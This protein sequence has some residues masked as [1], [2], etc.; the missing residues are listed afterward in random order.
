MSAGEPRVGETVSSGRPRNGLGLTVAG[1]GT[2]EVL[3]EHQV[4]TLA[5]TSVWARGVGVVPHDPR[6]VTLQENQKQT[7]RG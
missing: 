1:A 7:L 3:T 4:W 6:P 2:G 5:A